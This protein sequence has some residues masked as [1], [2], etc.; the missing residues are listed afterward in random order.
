LAVD[1]QTR[2]ALPGQEDSGRQP[3]QGSSD[4]EHWLSL[5]SHLRSSAWASRC[6]CGR[7]GA[8]EAAARIPRRP[9][10]TWA[11]RR[12]CS[13]A[14]PSW[15]EIEPPV[16]VALSLRD[17]AERMANGGSERPFS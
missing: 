13:T 3:G 14:E 11:P 16:P 17:P 7:G 1:K 5:F 4:H 8:Q 6:V 12:A 2:H 10:V 9:V 15:R